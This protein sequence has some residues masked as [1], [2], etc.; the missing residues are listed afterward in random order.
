MGIILISAMEIEKKFE[1][2]VRINDD[3]EMIKYAKKRVIICSS[4]KQTLSKIKMV[5][6]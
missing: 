4:S 1:F 5:E 3:D 2:C 6:S